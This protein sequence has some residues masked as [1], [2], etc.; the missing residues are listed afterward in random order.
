MVDGVT[1]GNAVAAVDLELGLE[2]VQTQ[3][4]TIWDFI[5]QTS[6]HWPFIVSHKHAL[7]RSFLNNISEFNI[8]NILSLIHI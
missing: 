4:Q 3:H 5:V 1:G 6:S 2:I 8:V 7:V